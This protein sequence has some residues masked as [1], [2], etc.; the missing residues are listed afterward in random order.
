[1]ITEKETESNISFQPRTHL[2]KTRKRVEAKCEGERVGKHIDKYTYYLR[3]WIA[4][5]REMF[6]KMFGSYN[7]VRSSRCELN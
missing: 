6:G 5:V 1:M 7:V 3:H 2:Q 4:I